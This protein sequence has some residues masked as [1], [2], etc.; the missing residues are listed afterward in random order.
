MKMK[1]FLAPDIRTAL[2]QVKESLG[3]D[4]VILSNRKTEQGIE[5]VAAR[6]FELETVSGGQDS[7]RSQQP[8]DVPAP[9]S[10]SQVTPKPAFSA[11]G[12]HAVA[13]IAREQIVSASRPAKIRKPVFPKVAKADHRP[14][15]PGYRS[16]QTPARVSQPVTQEGLKLDTPPQM[17]APGRDAIAPLRRELQQMRRLLDRHLSQTAWQE[18]VQRHPTRLDLMRALS[19]LGFSRQLALELAQRG[20][21]EEEFE[22]AWRRVQQ[23][24]AGQIPIVADPLLDRGGIV[25]LVGPTGVGKTTTIAKLAARFRL[26]HGPRQIAL[27]T[28][29]NYRIAAHEQLSTYARILGVPVRVAANSNELQAILHSFVD[30]RLV[31]IDT[32][33]MSQHDARLAQQFALLR[34]SEIAIESY[35]VLSASA[36]LHSLY[37]AMEAF[38]EFQPK[39]SILTK[40]DEAGCMGPALSALVERGLPAAFM[41]DGQQVPE[42]LHPACAETLVARRF[43]T[44]PQ[45]YAHI[46]MDPGLEDW[47]SYA[48][49]SL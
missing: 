28:T 25:A 41:A 35:L 23:V 9:P 3:P 39:A 7:S 46:E 49:V 18:E 26:K 21:V 30:K 34:D 11:K 5:I 27:V 40:L 17:P 29:D 24:L 37:E 36:Q 33:G 31:L 2:Q 15:R 22:G 44:D 1:R 8:T 10:S 32:A 43:E 45:S 4:A 6:D 20:G 48:S 47:M 14:S 38:A 42:D 16:V 13:E 19:E 12:Y